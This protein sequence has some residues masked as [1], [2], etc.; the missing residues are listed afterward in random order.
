MDGVSQDRA[1]RDRI[2]WVA[3]ARSLGPTIAAA[4]DEIERL[5]ELPRP[6]T[7]ALA[8]AGLFRLLQPRELGG[9]E[10]TPMEFAE[11]MG[12][13]A[14]Y[15]AS[16]AWCVGQGNGCG[17][18]A[19][20][21]DPAV[22]REIFGPV[23]G[24][25]AWGPPSNADVRKVPGGYR[26]TGTW[27]FASGSHNASWLGAH[28]VERGADGAPLRRADGGSVL[29]SLLFPKNA[30]Q[31]TDIWHVMGLRGTGSDQYSVTD[32]FVRDDHTVLHDRTVPARQGGLLYRFSF[33]NLY[34]S[35]FAGLAL[36]VARAFYD[37]FV[38]LAADKTPRGAKSTL[39]H[40]NV[41]QSQVAQAS[42]RLRS[43]RAFL[44]SS[45]GEIWEAVAE[46]GE[47]TLDHN[48]TIRLAST[49]AIKQAREVVDELYHAA[50][51][52][53]IFDDQPFERR[54]RDINTIAQQMQGAQRHFETVGGILLGLD[55]DATMFTF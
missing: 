14:G 30:A 53:A 32:L 46:T 44:L 15:D 12:E 34:A 21:L 5:R 13:I 50:G 8:E 25:L 27:N 51:A 10:V 42:A 11:V 33:S 40:N 36:G 55:P 54:F 19:A 48:A 43:A 16:T 37:S 41:V 20:Y 52:T 35:G 22:A 49:W 23:D 45:L 38:A 28:I 4:G 17:A 47:V 24:I 9:G 6:L 1:A 18:A 39:R 3:R 2:D 31:M 29:R 7:L 26:L